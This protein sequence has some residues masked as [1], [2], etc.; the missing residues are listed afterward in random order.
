MGGDPGRAE[1]GRVAVTERGVGAQL[2][3]VA[4]EALAGAP[5]VVAAA[6][7]Q[8]HLLE[9]VLAHVAAEEAPAAGARRRVAA[10][11]GAAPHIAHP[12]GVDLGPSG[13]VAHERVVGRDV[14]ERAALVA[15]HV[16]AQHLAQQRRPAGRVGEGAGSGSPCARGLGHPGPGVGKRVLGPQDQGQPRYQVSFGVGPETPGFKSFSAAY[17]LVTPFIHSFLI[18]HLSGIFLCQA[19]S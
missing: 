8:V 12:E 16:D 18:Y 6:L 7:H 11:E 4:L 9:L 17:Q 15:V 5:A 13:G 1:A 10:V 14:V 19:L 3:V 2:A